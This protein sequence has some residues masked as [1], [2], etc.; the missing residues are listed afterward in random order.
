[1]KW[2][3]AGARI[4]PMAKRPEGVDRKTWV[5][6]RAQVWRRRNI[7]LNVLMGVAVVAVLIRYCSAS[8]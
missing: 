2:P 8:A 1:M 5:R 7:V 6:Q 3:W 4:A